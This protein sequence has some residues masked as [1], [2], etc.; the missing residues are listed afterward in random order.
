VERFDQRQGF[1]VSALVHLVVLMTL[2]SH[3]KGVDQ[4]V[5]APSPIPQA[6]PRVFL[7]PRAEL[8][9]LFPTPPPTARRPAPVPTP[10]PPPAEKTKDRIS[11]GAP[12]DAQ[13]R[14]PLVL[15]RDESLLGAAK[16]R[17]DAVPSAAPP[18]PPT[19]TPAPATREARGGPSEV[20]N[21]PGLRMPPGL[22]DLPRP[23]EE[24]S[25]RGAAGPEPPS[26]TASLRNL[27]RRLQESGARG[28]PTGTTQRLGSLSF[29]P[30]GADF[31][32]WL[33]H[34]R[35]EVYNNWM[36]PKAFEL[37]FHGEVE[38]EFVVE[39]DGTMSSIRM[40]RSAGTPGLDRAA[41]NALL[42]SRFLPLP[43]DYGP[44]RVTM[45]VIFS[46]AT[47]PSGS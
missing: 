32:A 23:G 12:T 6:G 45:G 2:A 4:P 18:P 15:R 1:L 20:P 34:F 3:P 41:R 40:I 35:S 19:V 5:A 47:G 38:F 10:V 26:I 29:D 37:G 27:D 17:P 9:R 7:P 43:S 8:R 30:Q 46:Y 21:T 44:P 42:G 28:I 22:G 11:V 16:G 33:D 36:L 39:R 24:G 13:T 31:T 14:K 25:K